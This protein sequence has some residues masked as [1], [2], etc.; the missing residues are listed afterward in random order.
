[1]NNIKYIILALLAMVCVVSCSKDNYA[2]PAETFTG[3]FVEKGTGK[4]FQTAIGNTGIRIRMMEYSWSDNPIPYDTY[5]KQDGTFNNTKIFK[6]DYGITPEGAFVALPEEKISISGVVN[7]TYEVEPLLKVEWIGN[8]VVNADRTVTVKVKITRGT[9]NADYQQPLEKAWLF[10][11]ETDYVGDFSYSPNFSLNLAA[12]QIS[13]DQELTFTTKKAF[14]EYSRKYFLR[15]GAKT[16]KNF[17][18]VE[19]YNYTPI[20]EISTSAK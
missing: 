14:P 6:G 9:D 11:S 12:N 10:I 13:L 20:V 3:A 4:P 16:T 5:A 8:P 7:K 17:S 19:R 1:M 18:N 15:F 2:A